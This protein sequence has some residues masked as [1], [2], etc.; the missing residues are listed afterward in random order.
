MRILVTGSAGYIGRNLVRYLSTSD[1]VIGIDR[2]GE[3]WPVEIDS[4][5]RSKME[6]E[7]PEACVHLAAF[8]NIEAEKEQIDRVLMDNIW[9]LRFILRFVNERKIPIIFFSSSAV[10]QNGEFGTY[11]ASKV[12]G[13]ALVETM[14]KSSPYLII[15]PA[16]V[17]GALMPEGFDDDSNAHLFPRLEYATR[18]SQPF[19]MYGDGT[20][21]RH[22]VHVEDVCQFISES[23]RGSIQNETITITGGP[24]YSVLDVVRVW[25]MAVDPSLTTQ[26]VPPRRSDPAFVTMQVE[27]SRLH[28]VGRDCMEKT[29]SDYR[30]RLGG[31]T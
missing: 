16:N 29:L 5:F 27:D 14:V 20:Q 25:R 9:A 26:R 1:T 18:E 30:R 4:Q 23:L 28:D 21:R 31:D 7:R 17:V 19:Y 12:L 15:R 11:A 6:K 24:L 22:Y 3:P 13:E 10:Q 2:R 8:T